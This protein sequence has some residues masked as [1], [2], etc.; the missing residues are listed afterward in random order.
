MDY[1]FTFKSSGGVTL[2]ETR[3][4]DQKGYHLNRLVDAL[5]FAQSIAQ[6]NGWTLV[7]V[8]ESR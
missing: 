2:R 6:A 5:K 8:T 7:D 4:Y 3:G 1:K